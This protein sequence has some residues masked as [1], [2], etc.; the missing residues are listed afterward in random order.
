MDAIDDALP[1]NSGTH[2][3]NVGNRALTPFARGKIFSQTIGKR[4][5]ALRRLSYW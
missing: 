5:D 3:D 1:I 2:H 4:K